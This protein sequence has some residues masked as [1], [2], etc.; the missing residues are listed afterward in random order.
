[1]T[2]ISHHRH[3]AAVAADGVVHAVVGPH[4][5]NV[6]IRHA[7]VAAPAMGYA[8]RS[9]L[10]PYLAHLPEQTRRGPL[11]VQF[12]HRCSASEDDAR[13]VWRQSEIGQAAPGIGE[14]AGTR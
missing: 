8:E 10:G 11:F 2:Q 4:M 7:E 6:V 5:R 1:M 12:P 14:H 3:T 13:S 9:E